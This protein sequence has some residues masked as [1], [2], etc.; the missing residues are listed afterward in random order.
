MMSGARNRI[1]SVHENNLE[2]SDVVF[3]IGSSHRVC[4]GFVAWRLYRPPIPANTG[5]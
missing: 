1:R 3:K 2:Q 4:V 5:L